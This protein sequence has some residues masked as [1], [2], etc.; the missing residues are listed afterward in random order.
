[1]IDGRFDEAIEIVRRVLAIDPLSAMSRMGLGELLADPAEAGEAY[2]RLRAADTAESHFLLAEI[3]A[4]QGD[5]DAAY[6]SL[7]AAQRVVTAA[8]PLA[9]FPLAYET[10]ISTLLRPL[11]ADQRWEDLRADMGRR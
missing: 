2:E 3:A 9:N 5:F 11:R 7:A 10:M 6:E 4:R 1:V 8:G